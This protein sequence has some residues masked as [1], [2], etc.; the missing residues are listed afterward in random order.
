MKYDEAKKKSDK[1]NWDQAVRKKSM[2]VG[3]TGH[4]A[5]EANDCNNIP[6]G[7]KLS[8]ALGL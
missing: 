3:M 1:A 2:I 4:A 8:P 6:A 7:A 5:W